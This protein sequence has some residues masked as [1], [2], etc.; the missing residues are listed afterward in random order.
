M[1]Y[2]YLKKIRFY[3]N[4]SFSVPSSADVVI[5]PNR[6]SPIVNVVN[7]CYTEDIPLTVLGNCSNLILKE[8]VSVGLYY[9]LRTSLPLVEKRTLLPYNPAQLFRIRIWYP[10]SVGDAI[11]MNAGAFGGEVKDINLAYCL[12]INSL[13]VFFLAILVTLIKKYNKIKL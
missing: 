4:V 9:S 10:W 1:P 6:Y 13:I 12:L 7:Y 8:G 5:F 11:F 2:F 3:E